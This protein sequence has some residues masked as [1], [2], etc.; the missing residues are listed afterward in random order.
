MSCFRFCL[1]SQTEILLVR[2][3]NH[4]RKIQ[5]PRKHPG[6]LAIIYLSIFCPWCP[7]IF[8]HRVVMMIYQLDLYFNVCWEFT[9][10]SHPLGLQVM[11]AMMYVFDIY[12]K[13]LSIRLLLLQ[14]VLWDYKICSLFIQNKVSLQRKVTHSRGVTLQ[15][16]DPLLG[17][18]IPQVEVSLGE[19]ATQ[20]R[21]VIYL[22]EKTWLQED[23]LHMLFFSKS[24]F[25][26]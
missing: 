19:K 16:E 18:I 11:E 5:S 4:I 10:F 3:P 6:L 17:K 14:Y 15:T 12:C 24:V 9:N 2:L 20:E 21:R 7:L 26:N 8:R 1:G 13:F 22:K 25:P 23:T